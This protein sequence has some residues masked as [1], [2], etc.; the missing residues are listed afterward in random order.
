M[1]NWNNN[2]NQ[3]NMTASQP[4]QQQKPIQQSLDQPLSEQEMAFDLLYQEKEL[5]NC[6]TAGLEEISHKALRQVMQDAFKE[7]EQ[8]QLSVFAIMQQQGWYE[9]KPAAQQDVQTAKQKYQ[10]MRGTL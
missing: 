3:Q 8:D 6:T 5:M 9:V 4:W 2:T 7:I 1:Q 10:Q